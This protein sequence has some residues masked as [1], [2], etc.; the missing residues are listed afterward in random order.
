MIINIKKIIKGKQE[1]ITVSLKTLVVISHLINTSLNEFKVMNPIEK[2]I[3][4]RV[5]LI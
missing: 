1:I 5:K 3:L 4:Y 2:E